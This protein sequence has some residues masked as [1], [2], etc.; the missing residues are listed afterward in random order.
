MIEHHMDDF[1]A[2][3]SELNEDIKVAGS[4]KDEVEVSLE[5]AN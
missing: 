2:M 5:K 3:A 1:K 4:L